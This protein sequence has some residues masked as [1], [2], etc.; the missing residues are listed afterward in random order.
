MRTADAP[1]S[2]S[3]NPPTSSSSM[4]GARRPKALNACNLRIHRSDRILLQRSLGASGQ[5]PLWHR[6]AGRVCA[7]RNRDSYNDARL[8]PGTPQAPGRWA[9]HGWRAAPAIQREPHFTRGTLAFNLLMGP[10]VGLPKPDDYRDAEAVCRETGALGP[11]SRS[12]AVRTLSAGGRD[13]LGSFLTERRRSRI[14]LARAD[15]TAPR[16]LDSR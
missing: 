10:P 12:D 7:N 13:R 2:D 16:A 8:G 1:H 6:A 5:V 4:Q 9:A 11:A 14:F 15:P 3:R